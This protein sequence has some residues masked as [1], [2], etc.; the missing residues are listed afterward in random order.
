[1][2]PPNALLEAMAGVLLTLLGD[3]LEPLLQLPWFCW[4]AQ[5]RGSEVTSRGV[6]EQGPAVSSVPDDPRDGC[7]KPFCALL[8]KSS[9]G[10]ALG[11]L[12]C[13]QNTLTLY[14]VL[15]CRLWGSTALVLL[16]R[17]WSGLWSAAIPSGVLVSSGFLSWAVKWEMPRNSGVL[18]KEGVNELILVPSL[19]QCS[20]GRLWRIDS[21]LGCEKDQC[22][23]FCS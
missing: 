8:W 23:N 21:V 16:S 19:L 15:I 3:S 5:R 2:T 18:Q 7:S 17:W 22:L 9:L 13:C 11:L 1:M 6:T 12:C 20:K 4:G 14:F 10:L